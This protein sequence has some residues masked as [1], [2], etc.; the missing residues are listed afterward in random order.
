MP[1]REDLLTPIPGDNPSG[2]YL[3][4]APIYDKIK[5]A[6]RHE[7]DTGPSGVWARER[8]AADWNLVIKLAGEALATQSKDIQLA[9][10]LAEAYFK[11][12]G[13]LLLRDSFILLRQLVE[14]FW[15]TIYPLVE[16]GDAE[17][18]ATPLSWLGNFDLQIRMAQIGRAHV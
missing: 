6:R 15:D 16:E 8:K 10:W 11:K 4:Y 12:E 2:A 1:L 5:E 13:F 7:D 3:Y 9:V 17:F 18:R 14:T